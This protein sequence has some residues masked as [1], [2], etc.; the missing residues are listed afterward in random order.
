MKY[1]LIFYC[2]VILANLSYGQNKDTSSL[3]SLQNFSGDNISTKTLDRLNNSYASLNACVE[4]ESMSLLQKFQK[5]ESKL[6]NQLLQTDSNKAQQLFA[7]SEST[8]QKLIAKLQTPVPSPLNSF[9]NYIPGIDSMKTAIQFLAKTGLPID[10]ISK[11]E[12]ISL[13]LKQLQG[14]F[15]NANDIQDYVTQRE[16]QL[17][18]QLTQYGF[19]KQLLN[20][21]KQAF[22]YQQQLSQY[23]DIL[24]DQQ[25]QEQLI[26]ATIRQL[27]AFQSFWQKNSMLAQ[28]FPV[29]GNSGTVLAG[30]GLQTNAQ[31]GKLIQE[32][33]GTAKDDGGSNASQY[34][35]QQV[36]GAQGQI[37]Q[38][39]DRLSR[40]NVSGGS[41]TMAL[42]DFTPN[43]QKQKSLLKRFEF[44]F[45]IQNTNATL[46]LP[47]IS[48]IGLSLGY[49]L[50]DNAT[51]GIGLNYL[52]GLG[53]SITHIQFSNQGAGLRSY[54]EIKAKGTIWI[55]GGYEYNYMQQFSGINTIKNLEVW[56][57]SA[58]IGVMKKYSVGKKSG[59]VQLLYD[60]LANHEIPR[61]Q[62]L[63]VRFG[64]SL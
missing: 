22:Y 58:L 28:L 41:S 6:K 18:D 23:K 16:A 40:L 1:I 27:P 63:V 7:N 42:P 24:N 46:L 34:L 13:Q 59:N 14:S 53:N 35:K 4:K 64:F 29:P 33:L 47:A 50:N 37:D 57:K 32:K 36:G 44:G 54:M 19:A 15:Q 30:V 17:N 48:T 11:L 8:Y 55:T 61:G 2:V 3:T 43:G 38:L 39:K 56:Q 45:N 52:L 51:I 9:R 12:N 5:Q 26:L 20:M 25:K 62:A 60:L 21:N 10:K 49:K 31:V